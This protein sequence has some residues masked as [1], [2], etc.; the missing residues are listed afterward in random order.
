MLRISEAIEYAAERGY[1]TYA[2]HIRN[3]IVDGRIKAVKAAGRVSPWLVDV[4]SLDAW[5]EQNLERMRKAD[6]NGNRGTRNPTEEQKRRRAE[7]MREYNARKI[8][9]RRNYE[10]RNKRKVLHQQR[11]RRKRKNPEYQDS[12][13]HLLGV[14]D[15]IVGDQDE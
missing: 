5:I 1:T 12:I 2:G 4:E 11:V 13:L 9:N 6:A 14:L 8:Q 15:E 7:Y 10:E 3:C